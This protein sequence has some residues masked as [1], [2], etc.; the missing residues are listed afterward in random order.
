[1]II[2]EI[3][4]K[5]LMKSNVQ[6]K[7]KGPFGLFYILY[8]RFSTSVTKYEKSGGIRKGVEEGW[9]QNDGE[10]GGKTKKMNCFLY[11]RYFSKH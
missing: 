11:F 6:S 3:H 7:T 2:L 5:Q 10:Y 9:R 4:R 8:F 1:M